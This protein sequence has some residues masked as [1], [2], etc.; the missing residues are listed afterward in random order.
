MNGGKKQSDPR[1]FNR[2]PQLCQGEKLADCAGWMFVSSSMEGLA[3]S[4]RWWGMSW[5]C[6]IFHGRLSPFSEKRMGSGTKSVLS[7]VT[8]SFL[9]RIRGGGGGGRRRGRA[10]DRD[11]LFFIHRS[12]R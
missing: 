2:E 7:S 8:E 5:R 10:E 1:H 9:W 3:S 4:M 11:E 12:L 6:R